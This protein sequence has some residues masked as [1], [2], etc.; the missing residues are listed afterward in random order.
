MLRA[1]YV[2]RARSITPKS[3]A[4]LLNV[5]YADAASASLNVPVPRKSSRRCM[6][7]FNAPTLLHDSQKPRTL[8]SRDAELN[9]QILV[10]RV[11]KHTI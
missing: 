4:S 5:Y 7:H 10:F 3:K 8:P 6:W 1:I 9:F 11:P 2:V